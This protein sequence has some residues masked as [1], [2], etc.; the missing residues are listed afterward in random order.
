MKRMSALPSEAVRAQAASLLGTDL[1][2]RR[3]EEI[4]RDV[5]KI[6]EALDAARGLLDFND[7]PARFVALLDASRPR[8]AAKPEP[9]ASAG[10]SR[11]K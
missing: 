10:A 8:A 6:V 9:K 3:A 2:E 7:E 1:G 4:A 11:R 5:G